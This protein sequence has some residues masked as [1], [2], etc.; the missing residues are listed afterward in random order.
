MRQEKSEDEGMRRAAVEEFKE[1]H[2]K[3][4]KAGS[5]GLCDANFQF[6]CDCDTLMKRKVVHDRFVRQNK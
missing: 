2:E 6:T 1:R 4:E 3:N 5:H